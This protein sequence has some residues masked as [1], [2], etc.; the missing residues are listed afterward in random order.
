[1]I[2]P[3]AIVSSRASIKK[4]SFINA[5]SIINA[6]VLIN[7]FCIS[8]PTNGSNEGGLKQVYQQSG[9]ELQACEN[10]RN[11][12]GENICNI[13]IKDS[14]RTDLKIH[15]KNITSGQQSLF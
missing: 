15:W 10:M 6:G 8:C 12:W 5:G 1:M 3:S 7:N 4:G 2:H 13:Q 14:G 11:K 9:R